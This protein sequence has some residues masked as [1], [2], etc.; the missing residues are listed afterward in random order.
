MRSK[1]KPSRSKREARQLSL[2]LESIECRYYQDCAAPLCPSDVCFGSRIWFPREPV[3][4]LKSVP[5]WVRKQRKIAKLRGIDP[6][7]YFTFRMLNTIP[8][9]G[10]GLEGANPDLV[11]AE[12]I[13]FTRWLGKRMRNGT[14][15]PG[16]DIG[17]RPLF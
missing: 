10:C 15:S 5:D 7:R 12:R 1:I 16:S 4:R 2:P 3:C 13:W 17:M 6:D 9:V 11:T 14:S 8:R